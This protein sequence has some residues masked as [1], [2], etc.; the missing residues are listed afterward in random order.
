MLPFFKQY[1]LISSYTILIK[2]KKLMVRIYL[3]YY[4]NLSTTSSFKM[5]STISKT[6]YISCNSLKIIQLRTG[7]GLYLLST[8]KGLMFHTDA[9]KLKI[10]GFIVAFF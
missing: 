3:S 2:N 6:F 10:G 4:R 1:S 5:M 8:S 9:I 7:S